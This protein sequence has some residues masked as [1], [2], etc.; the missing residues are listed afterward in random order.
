MTRHVYR[1]EDN[2]GWKRVELFDHPFAGC[3]HC[4][5]KKSQERIRPPGVACKCTSLR[6]IGSPL[7]THQDAKFPGLADAEPLRRSIEQRLFD[8]PT[9]LTSRPPCSQA[10]LPTFEGEGQNVRRTGGN[11]D[12]PLTLSTSEAF[13]WLDGRCGTGCQTFDQYVIQLSYSACNDYIIDLHTSSRRRS[14]STCH[15]VC[16]AAIKHTYISRSRP[17]GGAE[18]STQVQA[19]SKLRQG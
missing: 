19:Q 15:D 5:L 8:P 14:S 4:F 9:T 1:S 11:Y 6:A 16:H 10:S 13:Q 2:R 3:R 7:L 18:Q 12:Q 17:P